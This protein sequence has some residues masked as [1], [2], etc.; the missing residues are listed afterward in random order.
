MCKEVLFKIKQ[1][2]YNKNRIINEY[3]ITLQLE[4]YEST[5]QAND[6]LMPN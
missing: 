6:D 4:I 3:V 1:S 5:L 2:H